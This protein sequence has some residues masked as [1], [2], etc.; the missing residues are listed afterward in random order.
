VSF[1][2]KFEVKFKP[3]FGDIEIDDDE[4][5]VLEIKMCN[6]ECVFFQIN[7]KSGL[8]SRVANPNEDE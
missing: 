8:F 4:K 6:E 3:P 2:K 1:T 7:K 5:D